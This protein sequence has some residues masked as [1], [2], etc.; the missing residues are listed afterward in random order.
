[1]YQKNCRILGAASFDGFFYPVP[2]ALTI[3]ADGGYTHAKKAGLQPDIV[4]GDFDSLGYIPENETIV[5]HP[6]M[7]D[8]TDLLLAA[9]LGLAQG[10]DTFFIYGGTGGARPA[11]TI[12]NIQILLYLAKRHAHG[13]L[14]GPKETMTVIYNEALSFD[15]K[16]EGM[17]SVF[18]LSDESRGVCERGL[19]YSLEAATLTHDYPLGISN[20]FQK[21][22]A[23]LSVKQGA[24][25]IIW[26]G[27]F[28]PFV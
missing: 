27:R 2:Y 5:R 3:A 24:L 19:L 17:V 16:A 20:Q 14:V 11:H 15:Q 7:K 23:L 1:M 22:D 13:F 21:K 9:D 26:E 18:S 8:E 25:L 28:L 6:V 12:G 10:C 4:V